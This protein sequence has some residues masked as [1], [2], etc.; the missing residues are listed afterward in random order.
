MQGDQKDFWKETKDMK[1]EHKLTF[2]EKI[3]R[4]GMIKALQKTKGHVSLTAKL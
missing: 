1:K 3:Q 2:H 4:D